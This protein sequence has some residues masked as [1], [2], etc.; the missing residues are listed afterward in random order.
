MRTKCDPGQSET[1]R[2][3]SSEDDTMKGVILAAKEI[4]PNPCRSG[5]WYNEPKYLLVRIRFEA[6]ETPVRICLKAFA[7]TKLRV[8]ANKENRLHVR[9]R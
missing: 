1:V 8:V 5:I 9:S 3:S 7:I 2:K 4:S 6:I